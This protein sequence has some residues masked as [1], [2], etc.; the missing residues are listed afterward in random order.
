M[1]AFYIAISLVQ[2]RPYVFSTASGFN[3]FGARLWCNADRSW[4]CLGFIMILLYCVSIIHKY[5]TCTGALLCVFYTNLYWSALSFNGFGARRWC[6][7]KRSWNG[8][9]FIKILLYCFSIMHK[10]FTC[11][12]ALLC[13]FHTNLYWSALGFN[14]FGARFCCSAKRS[15]NCI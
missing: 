1:L 5:F 6:R 14:G 12:G 10:D 11:T 8:V 7:A 4:N 13:V 9:G 2:V 3:R 15:W